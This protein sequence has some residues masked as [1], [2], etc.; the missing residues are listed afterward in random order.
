M[1][2]TLK[3]VGPYSEYTYRQTLQENGRI[4][5][6]DDFGPYQVARWSSPSYPADPSNPFAPGENWTSITTVT[7]QLDTY[8]YRF[9]KIYDYSPTMKVYLGVTDST[10]GTGSGWYWQPLIPDWITTP[11]GYCV[12]V[13]RSDHIRIYQ[14]EIQYYNFNTDA[15]ISIAYFNIADPSAIIRAYESTG[16]YPY[17]DYT[18]GSSWGIFYPD[19]R[20]LSGYKWLDWAHFNI[21][22]DTPLCGTSLLRYYEAWLQYP[23]EMATEIKRTLMNMAPVT[24]I[25][26]MMP[27]GCRYEYV[28]SDGSA[29][30]WVALCNLR[31]SNWDNE[32]VVACFSR[33][34]GQFY[35]YAYWTNY[36]Y[37]P[38]WGT[39]WLN[40]PAYTSAVFEQWNTN[41]LE[42]RVNDW[43]A[44]DVC[45]LASMIEGLS[46]WISPN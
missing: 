10:W 19:A 29:R 6:S 25:D 34:G 35:C 20:N 11:T 9:E 15:F 24:D 13:P 31:Y 45:G 39:T 22:T 36:N 32:Q 18:P 3:N 16:M 17:V 5:D 2:R 37:F 14:S 42:L 23:D 26:F 27:Q 38:L 8:N 40:R 21:H 4:V 41:Q 7:T 46:H 30:Y 28:I 12:T 43:M 44:K 33:I 1:V